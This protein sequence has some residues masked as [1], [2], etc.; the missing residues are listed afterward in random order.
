MDDF[1]TTDFLTDRHGKEVSPVSVFPSS[2]LQL[3]IKVDPEDE[4]NITDL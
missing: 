3:I 1:D 2:R 4:R